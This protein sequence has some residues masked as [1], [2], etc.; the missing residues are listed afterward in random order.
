MT[1]EINVEISI[2]TTIQ[3][4]SVAKAAGLANQSV[5]YRTHGRRQDSQDGGNGKLSATR[6]VWPEVTSSA[7]Y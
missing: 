5:V 3:A 2:V 4:K 6:S 7:L 1:R